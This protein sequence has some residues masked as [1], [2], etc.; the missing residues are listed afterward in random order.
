MVKKKINHNNHF[1][2]WKS[3]Q[4]LKSKLRQK[5]SDYSPLTG[6]LP[7]FSSLRREDATAVPWGG[8]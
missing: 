5:A 6:V 1:V 4:Y 2:H 8:N 7:Q 3:Q